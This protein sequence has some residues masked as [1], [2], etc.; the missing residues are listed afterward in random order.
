MSRSKV[1]QLYELPPLKG[2]QVSDTG[3][4]FATRVPGGWLFESYN[5]EREVTAMCFVPLDYEFQTESK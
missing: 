2:M 3:D 1:K 4:M 5:P